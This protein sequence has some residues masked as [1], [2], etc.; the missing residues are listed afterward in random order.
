MLEQACEALVIPMDKP[1][2]KLTKKQRE[3]ILHGSKK[4]TY[5]TPDKFEP[6]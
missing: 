1:F 4:A 6:I 2:S 3:T 5:I